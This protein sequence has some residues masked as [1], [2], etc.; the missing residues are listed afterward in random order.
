MINFLV[1]EDNENHRKKVLE[2]INKYMMKNQYKYKVFEFNDLTENLRK[3]IK[4]LYENKIYIL[5]FKLTNYDAIDVSRTIRKYDWISPIIILTAHGGMALETF[6]ERLQIL[7]FISKQHNAEKNLNDLF[8]I[9]LKQF[10]L[11]QNLQLTISGEKYIINLNQI[12]YIYRDSSLRKTV[13][14]T[15]NNEYKINSSVKEMGKKLDCKFKII[16]KGCIVNTEKVVAYIWKENKVIFDDNRSINML[17]STH[18]KELN[19]PIN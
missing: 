17:S 6:K 1:V 13:I 14:V 5:D 7:D 4:V 8:D 16:G 18:K 19:D 15:C 3:N 9:C 10:N 11:N 2:V 12:Y